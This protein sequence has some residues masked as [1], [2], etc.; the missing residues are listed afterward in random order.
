VGVERVGGAAPASAAML[1]ILDSG[2]DLEHRDLAIDA[3]RSRDLVVDLG[4]GS[5]MERGWATAT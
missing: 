1:W 2:I 4:I 3:G 5:S